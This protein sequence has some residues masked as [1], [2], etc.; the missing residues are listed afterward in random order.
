MLPPRPPDNSFGNSFL[1]TEN[2]ILGTHVLLEAAK[3]HNV[4]LFLHVSTD[5]VYGEGDDD[6]DHHEQTRLEPTNPYAATKAGAEYLV[7]AYHRS[8]KLPTIITRGN[9]V[10]G[11]HQF[12][13]KIIPKFTNQLMRGLPLYVTPPRSPRP[14]LALLPATLVHRCCIRGVVRSAAAPRL[15]VPAPLFD[16]A[17]PCTAT[18]PTSATSCSWR[19]WPRPST[20][21]CTRAPSA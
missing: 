7:K 15:T 1:F 18:A 16:I 19:M 11:P 9:N 21:S 20:W 2:N 10:F 8:F 5:E 6:A 4:K 13:E 14:A 17:G 3:I 12:P